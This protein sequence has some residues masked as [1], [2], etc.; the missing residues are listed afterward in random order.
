MYTL[1]K[2]LIVIPQPQSARSVGCRTT[3]CRPSRTS[4]HIP[5]G[6]AGVWFS[7][8]AILR[9]RNAE[10]RNDTASARIANGAVS[11]WT[12]RPASPGPPTLAR[13]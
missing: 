9:I 4:I 13:A 8:A 10:T 3:A 12:S 1:P 11:S 6:G 2:K 7:G 5:R